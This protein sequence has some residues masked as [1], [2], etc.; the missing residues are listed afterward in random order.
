MRRAALS[1]LALS[2]ATSLS[3]PGSAAPS[4]AE[5][6]KEVHRTVPLDANGSLT[7]KT[8]KGSVTVATGTAPEVRIDARIE[9]DGDGADQP[10][11]VQETRVEVS[12]RGGAVTVQ[13]DYDDVKRH[14]HH[15]FFPFLHDDDGTL[16]FVRY[17]ITMPK[18]ARL[19]VEDYKSDVDVRG[20]SADLR[21]ETYKGKVH[22]DGLEGAARLTTY[23]GEM[24]VGLVK[25]GGDLRLSTYKGT[26]VLDLPRASR[27]ELD[28]DTGRR[29]S[30]ESDFSIESSSYAHRRWGGEHVR[31]RVNGGGPLVSFET[32]KGTLRL[33]ES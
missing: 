6:V 30:V 20:L 17:T 29:G 25:M 21:I 3:S 4:S 7:I 33:R 24:R 12:G 32:Y 9:P 8:Y 19:V 27:F 13:S 18:T 10:R 22:V 5:A 14:E 2:L 11:K 1:V 23:K 26:F 16:P 28:A 15:F 31:T